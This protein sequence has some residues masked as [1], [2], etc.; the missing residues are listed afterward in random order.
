MALRK[1]SSTI[2]SATNFVLADGD[3]I[4]IRK[5]VALVSTES[6]GIDARFAGQS[7]EVRGTV[8]GTYALFM[9]DGA[10]DTGQTVTVA[11][12]GLVSGKAIGLFNL[13][14]SLNLTNAGTVTGN[15]YGI[16][17]IHGFSNASKITNTGTIYSDTN[18]IERTGG[19]TGKLTVVNEGLIA[20][21]SFSFLANSDDLRETIINRGSIVGQISLGGGND[22]LDSRKGSL[23]GV[24]IVDLGAGNDVVRL[25]KIQTILAGGDGNDTLDMRSS[26]GL[27]S[28]LDFFFSPSGFETIL[29]STKSADD[30]ACSLGGQT[31]RTFGGNDKITAG[32]TGIAGTSMEG[33]K[34]AD[35]LT[36]SGGID[37]FVY[38][39]A[40]EGG[41][42]VIDFFGGAFLGDNILIDKAGFGLTGPLG[43]L[44]EGRF[45][46]GATNQAGDANDRFIFRTTD[47]TLWFDADGT[48]AT[49]AIKLAKFDND[50]V[51]NH[52]DIEII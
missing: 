15:A 39:S 18:A 9:G 23:T 40:S 38:R 11:A 17:M 28:L 2:S 26:K 51:F 48:G 5:N 50:T 49:A 52:F 4:L 30:I 20:G 10:D 1:P 42:R 47:K 43:T 25:S 16:S 31:I 41:D 3:D 13:D 33:G 8:S 35:T 45:R 22:V 37:A 44:A 7:V 12:G 6:F 27:T 14:A 21:G 36:G 19:G 34:G 29:G 32:N 46:L 24:G